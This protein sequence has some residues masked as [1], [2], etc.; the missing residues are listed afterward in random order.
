MSDKPEFAKL[1]S[2][3][4]VQE[5]LSV[6]KEKNIPT[7]WDRYEQMLPQCGFG[8][9]GL[10]CRHCLQGPCRINPFE[11]ESQTGICGATVDVIVA[12]GLLRAIAAGTAAHSGH[13]K[14]LA[15]TMLKM[16]KGKASDYEIK[17]PAKLKKVAKDLGFNY[18]PN[19]ELNQEQQHNSIWHLL[20]T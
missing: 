6:A 4:A 14:H 8:E 17:D 13:A 2:D 11:E 19:F 10:C 20:S 12:R 9:T 18:I 15:H 16:L 5:M 1:T 3:P 7:V